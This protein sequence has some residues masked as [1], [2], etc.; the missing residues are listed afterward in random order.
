MNTPKLVGQ[1]P[2]KQPERGRPVERPPSLPELYAA[3][4]SHFAVAR[5]YFAVAMKKNT[6]VMPIV[7]RKATQTSV[8]AGAPC[9]RCRIASTIVVNGFAS[10]NA[11]SAAGID[12]TGTKAEEMKV[13][14]KIVMNPNAFAASGVEETIPMYA[15]THENA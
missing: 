8:L 4:A 1:E 9:Q 14:G 13:S 7:Q 2:A 6:I 15:N 5:L 3:A 11:S 12:S 10:A